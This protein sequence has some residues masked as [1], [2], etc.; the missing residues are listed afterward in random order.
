MSSHDGVQP[1]HKLPAH[2]HGGQRT[3]AAVQ[4]LQSSLDVGA[5][6]ALVELVHCRANPQVAEEALHHV[7]HT[8]PALA[9]HH[10]RILLHQLLHLLHCLRHPL[11]LTPVLRRR[12]THVAPPDPK[13]RSISV[14]SLTNC[15]KRTLY[16]VDDHSAFD[17]KSTS[18]IYRKPEA[19]TNL[20]WS[21]SLHGDRRRAAVIRDRELV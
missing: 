18:L 9:E 7:T 2:E 6:L 17:D 16:F 13:A 5:L 19:R 4:A 1:A 15:P 20:V 8:A 10:H 11:L 12:P 21:W 14:P 3:S